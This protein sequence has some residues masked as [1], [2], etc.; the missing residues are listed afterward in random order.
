VGLLAAVALRAAR[1]SRAVHVGPR[2]VLAPLCCCGR[3]IATFRE[4]YC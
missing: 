2:M 1:A 4:L 3:V